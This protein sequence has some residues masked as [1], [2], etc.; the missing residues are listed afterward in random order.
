LNRL[1]ACLRSRL[2]KA[3]LIAKL[4]G[5]LACSHVTPPPPIIVHHLAFL[6]PIPSSIPKTTNSDLERRKILAERYDS[7]YNR[8]SLPSRVTRLLLAAG[9]VCWL[10]CWSARASCLSVPSQN[11]TEAVPEVL[12]DIKI[13]LSN[14]PC[15]QFFWSSDNSSIPETLYPQLVLHKPSV[16]RF[17]LTTSPFPS[18]WSAE[19]GFL[20]LLFAMA[21]MH[22]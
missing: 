15:F 11:H 16:H 20:Q 9:L 4:S 12:T 14:Q 7:G 10:A 19:I 8:R 5:A 2:S 3:T 22:F 17:R 13:Q 6:S 21:L 18:S 1:V